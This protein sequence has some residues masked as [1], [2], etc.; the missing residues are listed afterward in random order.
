[1]IQS[2]HDVAA[3]KV[4]PGYPKSISGNWPG[5]WP[6]N[7]DASVVWPNGK[8]YFFKGPQYVRYD[9]ATDKADPGYPRAYFFKGSEVH[10]LQHRVR[11]DRSQYPNRSAITG[12]GSGG[13]GD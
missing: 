9:L 1:M 5:L 4:D 2:R 10:T 12:P 3:E 13:N 6:D 7:I 11:Q 8:A